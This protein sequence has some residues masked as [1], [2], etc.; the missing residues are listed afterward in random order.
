MTQVQPE[1]LRALKTPNAIRRAQ[2]N[3]LKSLRRTAQKSGCL[4]LLQHS[5]NNLV[6]NQMAK[7][8]VIHTTITTLPGDRKTLLEK[9]ILQPR[10]DN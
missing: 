3:A 8:F 2:G 1:L 7:F 6:S 9:A 4:I 5:K 10:V